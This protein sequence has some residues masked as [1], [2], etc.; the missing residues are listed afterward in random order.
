MVDDDGTERAAAEPEVSE[1]TI[2]AICAAP[3]AAIRPATMKSYGYRN[4]GVVVNA[5][6]MFDVE[7]CTSIGET[8]IANGAC[9]FGLCVD[10]VQNVIIGE[11]AELIRLDKK[12]GGKASHAVAGMF[13]SGVMVYCPVERPGV[14]LFNRESGTYPEA[15][16]EAVFYDVVCRLN[17]P[18][19][20]RV[21]RSTLG[22]FDFK[23]G[24]KVLHGMA[25]LCASSIHQEIEGNAAQGKA[26]VSLGSPVPL[27]KIPQIF[28]ALA[29][30]HVVTEEEEP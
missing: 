11:F 4:L 15:G 18:L 25:L 3:A 5:G 29:V 17:R 9:D 13:F 21:I 27:Q 20:A 22:A 8:V 19:P 24:K 28:P 10:D 1:E 14:Q 7:V 6:N 23:A 2:V 26:V 16:F 12:P 30:R